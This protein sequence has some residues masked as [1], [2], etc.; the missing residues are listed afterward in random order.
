MSLLSARKSRASALLL[1]SL[2]VATMI[3]ACQ[4][5]VTHQKSFMVVGN[6][7]GGKQVAVKGEVSFTGYGTIE[8]FSA[9][10]GG[11]LT[12][13]AKSYSQSV[14]VFN[15][16]IDADGSTAV[17]SEQ[18]VADLGKK[19]EQYSVNDPQLSYTVTVNS[20]VDMVETCQ[21]NLDNYLLPKYDLEPGSRSCATDSNFDGLATVE[22]D[23]E[24]RT[25]KY[26]IDVRDVYKVSMI[27]K[28][29]PY[30]D[31]IHTTA[32]DNMILQIEQSRSMSHGSPY[33]V[34]SPYP[35]PN[36]VVL[37]PAQPLPV[38]AH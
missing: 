36:G 12:Q 15:T 22:F 34:Q 27:L 5:P 35:V 37:Q 23:D 3:V 2:G 20:V 14:P 33:G 24:E 29:E 31:P 13:T 4:K 8:S 10:Y 28:G 25:V 18:V 11:Y 9:Q 26:G 1:S 16:A 19:L 30:K 21:Y 17:I 6:D 38:P 32:Q 7:T